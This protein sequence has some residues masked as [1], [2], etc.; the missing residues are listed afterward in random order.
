MQLPKGETTNT[1]G[2]DCSVFLDSNAFSVDVHLGGPDPFHAFGPRWKPARQALKDSTFMRNFLLALLS[3][4]FLAVAGCTCYDCNQQPCACHS[5]QKALCPRC[6]FNP[7]RCG[8]GLGRGDSGAGQPGYV[9]Y[10]YYT[11]RGPR[12]FLDRNPPSIGPN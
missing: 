4:G 12:D 5:D 8:L 11:T 3:A 6:G 10:P 2:N 1:N 7:C 9:A